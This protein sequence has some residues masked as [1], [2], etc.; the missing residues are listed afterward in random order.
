M[1]R[2][3]SITSR[4][5]PRPDIWWNSHLI[6]RLTAPAL[7]LLSPPKKVGDVWLHVALLATYALLT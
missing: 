3:A 2:A 7:S 5:W 6:F 4:K 1:R